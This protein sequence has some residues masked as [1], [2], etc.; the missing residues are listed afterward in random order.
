MIIV[1]M[2]RFISLSVLAFC[3]L[4]MHAQPADLFRQG[5]EAYRQS[6]YQQAIEA[7]TAVL[8]AGYEN[9]D[10]YYNLGNAYYRTEQM[11]MA[12]L[13]YE[14]ALR[15]EPGF[16]EAKQNL[17]LANARTEDKI[18]PIPEFLLARWYRALNT[19][20][21]PTGWLITLL[22]LGVLVVV[23]A[24]L[25][26][27]SG[28]YQWRKT[29]FVAI[30]VIGVL[31]LVAI[32]CTFSSVNRY[33]R[34][35]RAVVTQPMVVVKGSPDDAGVDKLVLHEGT[36]LVVDE[37]LGTWYKVRLADGNTGWLPDTEIT[38]I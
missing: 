34:H 37:T 6:D 22:V 29:A 11:G 35:D 33:N 5:N 12:V 36:T 30:I 13:C 31:L 20:L 26:R 2:K 27:F 17:A 10:L 32:C 4:V 21:P 15:I 16:A 28:S 38:I 14:R 24:G 7:Y 3:F 1:E 18:T 8:D 9:A 19:L 25:I 23:A